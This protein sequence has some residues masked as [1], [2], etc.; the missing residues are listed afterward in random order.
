MLGSL[1]LCKA[2]RCLE[3][4][5]ALFRHEGDEDKP[6]V[7]V[8]HEKWLASGEASQAFEGAH[9]AVRLSRIARDGGKSHI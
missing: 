2:V 1:G 7:K 9:P 3:S 8:L 4:D 5:L 6:V